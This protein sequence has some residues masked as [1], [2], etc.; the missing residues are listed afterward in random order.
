[1]AQ[2][3][4]LRSAQSTHRSLVVHCIIF[5][6]ERQRRG[7]F[8][9]FYHLSLTSSGATYRQSYVAAPELGLWLG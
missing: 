4:F 9:V 2:S 3:L 1:M 5:G 7:M 8:I 6:P